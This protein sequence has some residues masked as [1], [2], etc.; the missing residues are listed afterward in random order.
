NATGQVVRLFDHV[1][2]NTSLFID[3]LTRGIYFISIRLGE[4]LEYRKF[5]KD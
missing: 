2:N 4:T 1:Q 5:I 3:D